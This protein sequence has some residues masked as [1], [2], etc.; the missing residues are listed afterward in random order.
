MKKYGRDGDEEQ[1]AVRQKSR[2]AVVTELVG[3]GYCMTGSQRTFARHKALAL[4]A[5]KQ[6]AGAG[7][8]MKQQQ[9]AE[10][11]LHHYASGQ[12]AV[13]EPGAWCSDCCASSDCYH[14]RWCGI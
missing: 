12:K 5:I 1:E 11:V 7:D 14:C 9:L 10:A 8:S 2:R 3:E 4:G 13:V 6:I